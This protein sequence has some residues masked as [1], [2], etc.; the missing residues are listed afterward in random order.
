MA[1][2]R[3]VILIRTVDAAADDDDGLPP[4]GSLDEVQRVMTRYNTAHDGAAAGRAADMGLMRLH[5]PGLVAEL[6]TGQP[7]V[8]Q[9]MVTMTDDDFAFPVLM[10][11]CREQKWTM[12]DPET[13]QRLKF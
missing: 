5:G 6:S 1:R 3:Q 4:M 11:L 12:M 10:R 13:G 8:K 7:E 2:S 9:I